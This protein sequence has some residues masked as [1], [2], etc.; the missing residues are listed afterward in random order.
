[1]NPPSLLVMF[2]KQ[3]GIP[4]YRHISRQT[5]SQGRRLDE[6]RESI[7]RRIVIG[8]RSLAVKPHYFRNRHHAFI[9]NIVDRLGNLYGRTGTAMEKWVFV[10]SSG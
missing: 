7:F 1:M 10:E 6:R 4:Y 2:N 8:R 3:R 5:D 9:C